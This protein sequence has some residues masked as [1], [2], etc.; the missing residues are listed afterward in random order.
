[1]SNLSPRAMMWLRELVEFDLL[2]ADR[3][4]RINRANEKVGFFPRDIGIDLIERKYIVPFAAFY[5]VTPAG[6]KAVG[7][8]EK[9]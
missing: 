3:L 9:P 4:A 8:K 7:R 5:R 2:V 6:R 1:M